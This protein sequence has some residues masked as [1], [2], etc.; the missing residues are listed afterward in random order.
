MASILNV[1]KIRATGST[2]DGLT[3]DSS[4]RVLTPARPAFRVEKRASNQS[5][6]ST[7]KITFEHEAFDIGSNYNTSTSKYVV[8]VAG[9][10]FFQSI[11][12][13]VADNGTL[14]YGKVMLYIN[15]SHHSDLQF[16]QTSNN[17]MSNS[18][19]SGSCLVQLSANDEAEIY[20]E[21]SG[22]NPLVHAHATGGRTFF[23]GFLV[24]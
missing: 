8:P 1:D 16:V 24:G 5:A 9:V 2:T 4:G 23:T 18:H 17:N 19:L 21:I 7:S 22:V 6:P 13:I 20:S 12:R 3:I 10:Y 15:G 14:D 11:L